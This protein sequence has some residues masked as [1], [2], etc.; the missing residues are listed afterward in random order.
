LPIAI[1]K[2][3]QL[4]EFTFGWTIAEHSADGRRFLKARSGCDF[5]LP[6]RQVD[7]AGLA[8]PKLAPEAR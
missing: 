7:E 2:I 5:D 1:E 4:S 3:E 6:I 8:K